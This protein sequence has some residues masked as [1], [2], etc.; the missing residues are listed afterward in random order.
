MTFST[1]FTVDG[2]PDVNTSL[3]NRIMNGRYAR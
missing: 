1:A 2:S 3:R